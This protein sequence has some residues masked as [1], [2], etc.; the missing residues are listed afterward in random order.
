MQCLVTAITSPVG[1]RLASALLSAGYQVLGTAE[2]GARATDAAVLAPLLQQPGF[3]YHELDLCSRSAVMALFAAQQPQIVVHLGGRSGLCFLDKNHQHCVDASQRM[4][5]NLLDAALSVQCKH[6]IYSQAVALYSDCLRGRA[7]HQAS[8]RQVEQRQQLLA[9][10]YSA[11]H[12][13]CTS[14]L[15]ISG[16]MMS[17]EKQLQAARYYGREG[18]P[19]AQQLLQL[20][21][22]GPQLAAPANPYF[23]VYQ[24]ANH[25]AWRLVGRNKP[26]EKP[27]AKPQR[28]QQAHSARQ[29]KFSQ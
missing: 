18:I 7:R 24:A 2:I 12:R 27:A 13:L 9:H 8:L 11:W 10:T 16:L 23:A 20:V 5:L 19:L 3:Q 6:F 22:N 4:M 17:G 26:A 28:Q 29:N 25:Q 1:Q 21:K 15:T 14:G